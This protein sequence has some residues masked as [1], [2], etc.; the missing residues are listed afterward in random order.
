MRNQSTSKTK[1]QNRKYYDVNLTCKTTG[2][3]IVIINQYGMYCEDKCELKQ[4]KLAEKQARKFVETF[5]E[6]FPR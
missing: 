4:D 2:K 3:P 5:T 1:R 6:M